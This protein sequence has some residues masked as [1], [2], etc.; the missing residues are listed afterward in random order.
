V[1]VTVGAGVSVLDAV[2]K[3]VPDAPYSC[4]AGFCGTCETKVLAGEIDHRDDLLSERE[5]QEN[6]MMMICVSRS[7]GGCRLAL[8]L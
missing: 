7:R 2:L 6:N 4:T 1:T 8:D 5:Q 3:A